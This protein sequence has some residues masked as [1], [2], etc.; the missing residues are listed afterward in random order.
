MNRS[1]SPVTRPEGIRFSVT[2][3]ILDIQNPKK[4]WREHF[5]NLVSP[6]N[7][8]LKPT[9]I[10]ELDHSQN[11]TILQPVPFSD[12][13][14]SAAG[15]KPATKVQTTLRL[16]LAFSSHLILGSGSFPVDNREFLRVP[17]FQ[18]C[19]RVR[20]SRPPCSEDHVEHDERYRELL[21]GMYSLVMGSLIRL[22]M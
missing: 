12:K 1:F 10:T 20:S 21:M 18:G 4:P 13:T 7:G 9:G 3:N 16:I 2:G 11:Q 14:L 6:R 19:T 17:H 22:L 5:G 8:S 15:K